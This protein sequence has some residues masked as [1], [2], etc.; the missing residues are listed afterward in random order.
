MMGDFGLFFK[1]HFFEGAGRIPFILRPPKTWEDCIPAQRF[2]KPVSLIDIVS[3]FVDAAGGEANDV[4]GL[5]LLPTVRGEDPVG[6]R[7]FH[8]EIG[9]E[10]GRHHC[11]TDGKTK[12]TWF[13]N[14]GPEFLFDLEKDPDELSNL[15]GEEERVRP[16]RVR[17][18]EL[19]K[20]RHDHAVEEGK[21]QPSPFEATA[22]RELRKIFP[23]GR[24]PF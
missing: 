9:P 7:I 1:S 2:D 18:I 14:G 13:R 22:D 6:D 8:G 23:Y 12:Y 21:L 19:L 4:D 15:A 20:A 3:T 17:L 10:A 16:W 11:L 5:S 24:R